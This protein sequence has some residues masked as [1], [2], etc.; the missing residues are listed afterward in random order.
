MK[1]QSILHPCVFL[2]LSIFFQF[3]NSTIYV[4]ILY[5][6]LN[7]HLFNNNAEHLL[8]FLLFIWTSPNMFFLRLCL[9]IILDW[10]S[11]FYL[12][13]IGI[14]KVFYLVWFLVHCQK[15]VLPLSFFILWNPFYSQD[16][17]LITSKIS[18][19]YSQMNL[20]KKFFSGYVSKKLLSILR[21][22]WWSH[23]F[24]YQSFIVLPL[25]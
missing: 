2:I 8:L 9:I 1:F 5:C 21:L 3:S 6:G 22:W 25:T 7:V 11:F 24:S 23:I 14:L 20:S 4:V 18:I 16:C 15:Y 13:L 19:S 17:L 10:L 12:L